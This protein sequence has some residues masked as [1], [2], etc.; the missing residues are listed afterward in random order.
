VT[1]RERQREPS[2]SGV[3]ARATLGAGSLEESTS[4]RSLVVESDPTV[5]HLVA[6]ALR[7]AGHVVDTASTRADALALLARHRYGLVVSNLH[8][9]GLDG[10]TLCEELARHSP[11]TLPPLIFVTRSAFLPEYSKFL[12]EV[13]PTLLVKPVSPA[14]LWDC[15]ERLLGPR[16]T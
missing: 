8:M 13:G 12:M 3:T 11:R 1:Q 2:A 15:V 7:I 5:V 14:K 9:P 16:R 6:T 10:P 4:D